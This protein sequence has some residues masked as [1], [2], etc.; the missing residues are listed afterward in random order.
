MFLDYSSKPVIV[1]AVRFTNEMKDR[2]FNSLTGMYCADIEDGNPILKVT[3]VHGDISIVRIGD[4]IVKEQILGYYYPVTDSE[5]RRR[6]VVSGED[7]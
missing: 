3:T 6:Y 1:S 5:F 7:C 4:W 2:I